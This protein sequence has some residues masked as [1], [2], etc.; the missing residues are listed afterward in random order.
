M[1]DRAVGEGGHLG[2]VRDENH[3]DPLGVELLE[4]PQDFHAGVRIEVARRLVGQ[5]QGR[6]VDQRPRDGHALL[7]AAGHLR[8]LVVGAIGQADAVQ[9]HVRKADGLAL[10]GRCG[11]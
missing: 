9:Q 6:A 3:G 4:H 8:R 11:E 10:P 7:L 5:Q 1:P 2:I